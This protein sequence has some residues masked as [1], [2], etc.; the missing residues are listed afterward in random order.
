[1]GLSKLTLKNRPEIAPCGRGSEKATVNKDG[2]GWVEK[3]SGRFL[4]VKRGESARCRNGD[5]SY[6]YKRN[7]PF[8]SYG[9]TEYFFNFC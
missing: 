3:E 2:I 9:F 7:R 1:L 6:L 8:L 4:W 5:L